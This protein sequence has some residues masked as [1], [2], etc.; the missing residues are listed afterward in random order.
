MGETALKIGIGDA[1]ASPDGMEM[2]TVQFF[3]ATAA[4]PKS[5]YRL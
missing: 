3:T 1:D 2:V 5:Q 4:H